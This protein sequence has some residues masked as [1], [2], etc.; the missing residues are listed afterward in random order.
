M[1]DIILSLIVGIFL[2]YLIKLNKSQK[3]LLERSY[4]VVIFLLILFMGLAI[5]LNELIFQ[6]LLKIGGYA[7]LF[8]IFT[9]VGSIAGVIILEKTKI[10][11]L[12]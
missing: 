3:I 5:G 9:I 12:R 10:M 7:T 2:G 1:I 4:I 8:S 6:N 11:R